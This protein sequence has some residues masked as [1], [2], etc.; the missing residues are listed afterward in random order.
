MFSSFFNSPDD[1]ERSSGKDG[2]KIKSRSVI[3]DD[4]DSG[5]DDDPN[6]SLDLSFNQDLMK[7]ESGDILKNIKKKI[8]E[9]L[10]DYN[11]PDKPVTP[12]KERQSASGGRKVNSKHSVNNLDRHRK[13]VKD[14]EKDKRERVKEMMRKDYKSS[15]SNNSGDQSK[16]KKPVIVRRFQQQ[17]PPMN[18]NDLLKIAAE[19]TKEKVPDVMISIKPQ[20]K[21]EER[22]FTQEEIDRRNRAEEVK[23]KRAAEEAALKKG[24]ASN[25]S[26]RKTATNLQKPKSDSSLLKGALTGKFA[27]SSQ[28]MV[29]SK[30]KNSHDKSKNGNKYDV[31][32][33]NVLVCKPSS[34]NVKKLPPK[35]TQ[36]S[37]NPWDRIYGQIQQRNP[38]P[39]DC[40]LYHKVTDGR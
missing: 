14:R 29:S 16:P 22:L 26:E 7:N 25:S 2:D 19:K 39:G 20:K 18:F 12:K 17:P 35:D 5:D 8:D 24:A 37:T 34:S 36:P 40:T 9:K 6:A 23:R 27:I 1:K 33:E 10:S 31:E 15:F 4:Y 11:F 13:K 21:V 32:N 3:K 38:K 30:Q 28:P